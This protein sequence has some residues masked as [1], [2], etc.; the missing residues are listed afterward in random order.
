MSSKN[1]LGLFD[2]TLCDKVCQWPVTCQWFPPPIKQDIAEIL[3]KV[4][5]NIISII[6]IVI[7]ENPP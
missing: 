3:L 1:A 6:P 4:A 7:S 2:T 5:L